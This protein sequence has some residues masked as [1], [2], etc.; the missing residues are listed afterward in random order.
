MI[1][2]ERLED[3]VPEPAYSGTFVHMQSAS[4]CRA[5]S[6]L[7]ATGHHRGVGRRPLQPF[8]CPR[9]GRASDLNVG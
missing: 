2:L 4:Q 6:I 3:C 8:H 1:W 5:C 7:M 9:N